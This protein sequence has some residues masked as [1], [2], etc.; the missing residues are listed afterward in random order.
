MHTT[1]SFLPCIIKGKLLV[2]MKTKISLQCPGILNREGSEMGGP[3]GDN[4]V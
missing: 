3:D 1:I 2:N 4:V